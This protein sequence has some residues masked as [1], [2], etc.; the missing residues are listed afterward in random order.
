M[1]VVAGELRGRRLASVGG[2]G[3]RPT[4]ERARSGL[5][6]WLGGEVEGAR[7]LDLFAG[8]GSLG[9]EALS[10]G[11]REAVF[12]ER[13]RGAL[14]VLRRNL[15]QLGLQQVGRCLSGDV[16]KVLAGGAPEHGVF[17]LVI[18][19]PPY[20][21]DWCERLVSERG[22]A[23]L[24][25]D[26]GLLVIERSS[27]HGRPRRQAG[28]EWLEDRTYGGTAFDVYRRAGGGPTE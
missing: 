27:R 18:A 10:R 19:D 12:V 8:S 13:S 6:D 17:D 16:R 9:I 26:D 25:A 14:A 22:A 15:E 20:E 21:G 3:T 2:R 5:F 7:V 1:R 23:R 11:A 4:S 28:L 24:L